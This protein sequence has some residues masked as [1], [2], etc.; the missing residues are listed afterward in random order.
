[1]LAM[2]VGIV[3]GSSGSLKF[4]LQKLPAFALI[5]IDYNRLSVIMVQLALT[6]LA[7]LYTNLYAGRSLKCQILR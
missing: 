2:V 6:Q 1:M 3:L 5:L 7:F 4:S